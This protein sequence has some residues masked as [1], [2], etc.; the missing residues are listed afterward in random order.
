VDAAANILAEADHNLHPQLKGYALQCLSVLDIVLVSCRPTSSL[1][2]A[3]SLLG[4]LDEFR[5]PEVWEHLGRHPV[6]LRHPMCLS[7]LVPMLSTQSTALWSGRATKVLQDSMLVVSQAVH[8][9]LLLQA[10]GFYAE[11]STIF[12]LADSPLLS[13]APEIQQEIADFHKATPVKEIPWLQLPSRV[14][15]EDWQ[16]WHLQTVNAV[17]SDSSRGRH[18]H[19][20]LSTA[21][22]RKK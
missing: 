4:C 14:R 18:V 5:I 21:A 12:E 10:I 20:L 3:Y 22:R 7:K 16:R 1:G 17:L 11:H 6:L 15:G 9:F 19:S 2:M 8:R 13:R